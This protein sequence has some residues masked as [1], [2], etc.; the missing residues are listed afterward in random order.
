[1]NP[2][3]MAKH[4]SAPSYTS[5]MQELATSPLPEAATLAVIAL[6]AVILVVVAVLILRRQPKPDS[7]I[8]HSNLG[9]DPWKESARRLKDSEDHS[10]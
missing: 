1:M 6:G 7:K 2:T 9:L 8:K 5:L 4:G 10:P 3:P